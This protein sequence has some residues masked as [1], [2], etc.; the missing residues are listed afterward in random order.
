MP[1]IQISESEA[2]NYLDQI[3]YIVNMNPLLLEQDVIDSTLALNPHFKAER[4]KIYDVW[5]NLQVHM[6]VLTQGQ[7]KPNQNG[8]VNE[9]KVAAYSIGLRS[10]IL[11]LTEKV[12]F[13]EPSFLTIPI[14]RFTHDRTHYFLGISWS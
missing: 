11:Y 14:G 3:R 1:T 5:N 6:D 10:I 9:E 7:P 8:D 12:L 13:L 4:A 2:K